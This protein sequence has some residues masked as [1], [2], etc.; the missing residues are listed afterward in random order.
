[1]IQIFVGSFSHFNAWT[2][3]LALVCAHFALA[4]NSLVALNH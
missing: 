4:F 3:C 1:M 2:M